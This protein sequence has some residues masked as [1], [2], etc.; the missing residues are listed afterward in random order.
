MKTRFLV[1]LFT[2]LACS[3]AS[4]QRSNLSLFGNQRPTK[5]VYNVQRTPQPQQTKVEIIHAPSIAK[6]EAHA[7]DADTARYLCLAKRFGWYYG[8]GRQLTLE[9]ARH[10]P[11]Y[12]RLTEPDSLGRFTHIEAVNGKG[13][14]TQNHTMSTY[15]VS[16]DDEGDTGADSLWRAMLQ[17]VVQW[18]V[19]PSE[20]TL[21]CMESGLDADG[22]LIYTYIMKSL[23]DSIVVG[24]YTDAFGEPISLRSGK[25]S[26][27]YVQLVFDD[28]GRERKILYLDD[29][30][31]FKRNTDGA[32]MLQQ[33][34][35]DRGNVSRLI[36]CMMN[37][38]PMLDDWGNCG[39]YAF[40]DDMGQIVRKY[41]VDEQMHPM[42]LPRKRAGAID[43]MSRNFIYDGLR[44][45]REF[46]LTDIGEKDHT[47]EGIHSRHWEYDEWG[48]VLRV[49]SHD[50]SGA[51]CNDHYGIAETCFEYD[52]S[53]HQIARYLLD[54]E[55]HFVND[56]TGICLVR[57]HDTYTTTTGLDTLPV[58]QIRFADHETKTIDYRKQR[59]HIVRTDAK[60]R[61]T[62][63]SYYD[64][65]MKPVEVDSCFRL[66]TS[67]RQEGNRHIQEDVTYSFADTLRTVTI[68]DRNEATRLVQTFRGQTLL[69]SFGQTLDS[70][71][72]D[73]TGQ[74][75]YD[76]LGYRARSHLEDA[77]YYRVHSGTT[78]RGAT[79]YMMG[80]NEYD[81]PSYVIN[82]ESSTSD[83][84]CTKL[85]GAD[86]KETL[87]DEDNQPITDNAKFRRTLFRAYAIE[88]QEQRAYDVG[89]RSGDIIVKY[90]EFYYSEPDS[91]IWTP[92]DQLQMETFLKRNVQKKLLLLRYD[93]STKSP[94]L[95][96]L[97]LPKGTPEELGF[98]IQTI[99]YTKREARRHRE[100]V[101]AYLA[102][103][104]RS[105]QEF[106]TDLRHFG[107]DTVTLVRPF[108]ISTATMPSWR[109]GLRA[110]VIVLGVM[111]LLLDGT[112][113]YVGISDSQNKL[114]E[115]TVGE[116]D[117]TTIFFTENGRDVRQVTLPGTHSARSASF[118]NIP[119][120]EHEM[121]VALEQKALTS[122]RQ[123][124]F[125]EK[126]LLTPEMVVRTIRRRSSSEGGF[127]YDYGETFFPRFLQ[128]ISNQT[129]V[130]FKDRG[131][132]N[133]LGVWIKDN[134]SSA[135]ARLI[136][137]YF[138]RADFSDYE[139]EEA[140]GKTIYAKH[141]SD[142]PAKYSEI[143]VTGSSFFLIFQGELTLT[144]D[145]IKNGIYDKIH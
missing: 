65:A 60:G 141:S 6:T 62:E 129:D 75:G 48:N 26:A 79:S 54:K 39:Y 61:Q 142:D 69:S 122:Q 52:D 86:G 68:T 64:L 4:A 102:N 21:P 133:S 106:S 56:S 24:H 131:V 7:Q 135:D 43:V 33:D 45:Q 18:D 58:L 17:T 31:Y 70:S 118:I 87:L 145:E 51:L 10:L 91:S 55:K 93:D 94:R 111:N 82:S 2:T 32:Y 138:T 110:D 84:Y 98:L 11:C 116:C 42:R 50:E 36:S 34:Y 140:E 81:E 1:C 85:F 27:K 144:L 99:Y 123:G 37:G 38:H 80:R 126:S 66:L 46:Y 73:I 107:T 103:S 13:F 108:K 95:I 78:Y 105:Q 137:A 96:D 67:Y 12:Y 130:Q 113:S 35:D 71:L 89:L 15:L 92:R 121:L 59:I 125:P 57:G 90:G 30:A 128:L 101:E 117:S 14:L 88:L 119:S 120:E 112:Q 100:L 53:C 28:E 109:K 23:N 143:V 40:Y 83:V 20:G 25:N 49:T 114:W 8:I 47:K 127:S 104:G 19:T 136:R 97:T 63:S 3:F 29:N 134:T 115:Q 16:R 74:F 41:Y 44:L 139:K 22:N 5:K 132:T 9:E 77:L 76:A 72:Q 124:L